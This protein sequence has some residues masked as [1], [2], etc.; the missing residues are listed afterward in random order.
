[1]T[2]SY[3][4][5]THSY[6]VQT[7]NPFCTCHTHTHLVQIHDSIFMCLT[8]TEMQNGYTGWRRVGRLIVMGHFPQK[9]PV[10]S[11]SFAKNDLQLIRPSYESSP[12]STYVSC[13]THTQVDGCDVRLMKHMMLHT[14]AYVTHYSICYTHRLVVETYN[15]RVM[16]LT[17][18]GMCYRYTTHVASVTHTQIYHSCVT[19]HTHIDVWYRFTTHFSNGTHTQIYGIDMQLIF[20]VA[21]THRYMVQIY[22]QTPSAWL[23]FSR[24]RKTQV[25]YTV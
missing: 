25:V 15:A 3:V 10:I 22:D 20:Q 1:M 6:E 19:C 24:M 13:G 8:H 11:G 21:H 18:T 9:S 14:I 2:H 4:S 16:C 17:H 12:C 23:S 5:H 7:Y